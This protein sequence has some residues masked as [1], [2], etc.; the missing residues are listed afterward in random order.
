MK[1]IWS[2]KRSRG[3]SRSVTILIGKAGAPMG[4][5]PATFEVCFLSVLVILEAVP[6]VPAVP[7]VKQYASRFRRHLVSRRAKTM[8]N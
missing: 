2:Q 4:N 7:T 1:W 8:M 5:W 6:K 3:T